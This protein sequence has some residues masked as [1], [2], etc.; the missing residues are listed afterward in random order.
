MNNFNKNVTDSWF[1]T[2]TRKQANKVDFKQLLMSSLKNLSVVSILWWILG[3]VVY[4]TYSSEIKWKIEDLPRLRE[5]VSILED[6]L[7][8]QDEEFKFLE[9]VKVNSN[10]LYSKEEEV[11]R[12][13]PDDSE[14]IIADQVSR[15]YALAKESWVEVESIN[16]K[17]EDRKEEIISKKWAELENRGLVNVYNLGWY[18]NYILTI[19][20]SE[21]SLM[22]FKDKIY[23]NVEFSIGSFSMTSWESGVKYSLTLEWIYKVKKEKYE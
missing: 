8:K 10:E 18:N 6:N 20:S 4:T 9:M 12:H 1:S 19:T 22:R 13:V 16:I 14:T 17:T 23:N 3:F 7:K 11:G 5:D 21:E 2:P 15:L